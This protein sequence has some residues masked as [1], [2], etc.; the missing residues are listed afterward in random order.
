MLQPF[1]RLLAENWEIPVATL[2]DA[3]LFVAGDKRA[4]RFALSQSGEQAIRKWAES[5]NFF[6]VSRLAATRKVVEGWNLLE[7]LGLEVQMCGKISYSYVVVVAREAELAKE[8][9]ECE[10]NGCPKRAGEL[11][12]Y[13]KCCVENYSGPNYRPENWISLALDACN[14]KLP[15]CWC[16]RLPLM[17]QAPTFVGEIFPCSFRCEHLAARGRRTYELLLSMGLDDLAKRTLSE[18]LRP[19]TFRP[20]RAHPQNSAKYPTDN[21]QNLPDFIEFSA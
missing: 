9:C 8:L 3:V 16:N 6:V 11:L 13:P 5:Q 7:P 1:L 15:L 19:V 18:A 17:W 10:I 4:L 14:N 20:D 2:A 21:A 12:D